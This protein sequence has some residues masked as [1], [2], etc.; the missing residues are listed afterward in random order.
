M[1][2]LSGLM[3]GLG[4][5]SDGGGGASCGAVLAGEGS[6][7]G[8]IDTG[9]FI[10]NLD[11]NNRALSAIDADDDS[12]PP[13][14]RID[15]WA[16]AWAEVLAVV[17][18]AVVLLIV[19]LLVVVLLVVLLA[20]VGAVPESVMTALPMHA[21]LMLVTFSPSLV[22]RCKPLPALRCVCEPDG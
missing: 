5:A 20:V 6:G 1:G 18:L 15:A 19:V 7:R 14:P 12:L 8:G 11:C 13:S 2:A 10:D 16:T 9:N 3:E 4:G 17:L 21:K 22:S